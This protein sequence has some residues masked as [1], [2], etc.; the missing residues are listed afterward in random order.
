[1][2]VL[3]QVH[4]LRH[5]EGCFSLLVHLSDL[6]DALAEILD[7]TVDLTNL[8][9]LNGEEYEAALRLIQQWLLAYTHQ[10]IYICMM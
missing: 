6:R 1:M 5:P 3:G 10:L 7:D 4:F 2:D 8:M 9:V